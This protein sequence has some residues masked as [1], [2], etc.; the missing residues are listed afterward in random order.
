[1]NPSRR[2]KLIILVSIPLILLLI[3]FLGPKP[4]KPDFSSL[5]LS[6]PQVALQVLEDSI[7]QAEKAL[8][9]KHDNQARIVWAVPY[10]KTPYSIVYLHGNGASQEEGDPLH[11]ALADRYGCNLFLSRLE[12]CG[13]IGDDPLKELDAEKW[14]QSALNS[15]AI[16]KAI[17][18]KV[19][20]VSCSTGSTLGLYLSAAFPELV[21][22]HI[23]FSPNIDL[24][25]PRSAMLSKPWGLY[26]SR[27]TVNS[28]YYGWDAPAT[29]QRYW[30]TKYRI[31]GLITLKSVLEATMKEET[32]RKIHH[33]LFLAY[34]YKDENNQD[35]VVSVKR[36]QEMLSQV[37]TPVELKKEYVVQDAGTHLIA[38]DLFNVNVGTL[39]TPLSE[40]CEQVIKLSPAKESDWRLFLDFR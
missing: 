12:G 32:F 28:K 6:I 38:S 35:K 37:S 17:G 30:Y 8:P 22:A 20:L 19:I 31:E 14:M 13:L 23:M 33:P 27:L 1:M 29:A 2:K 36:M 26:L 9:V 18:E 34:Y 3:Y 21:D 4:S 7:N 24:H 15:I 10:E 5:R 16:G 25:D 39:W 11:E 40:F